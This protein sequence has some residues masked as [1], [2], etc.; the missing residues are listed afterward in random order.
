MSRIRTYKHLQTE[1][2]EGLVSHW[3]GKYRSVTA[4]QVLTARIAM[5]WHVH[6]L[7]DGRTD[8]TGAGNVGPLGFPFRCTSAV[9]WVVTACS[10]EGACRLHVRGQR[11]SHAS[12]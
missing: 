3:A 7:C 9:L 1:G 5:H 4:S 10:S 8:D 11:V 12:N 2:Q 6:W